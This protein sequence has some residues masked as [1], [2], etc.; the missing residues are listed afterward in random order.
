MRLFYTVLLFL[1]FVHPLLGQKSIHYLWTQE[2]KQWVDGSGKVD[3]KAWKQNPK[4]LKTYLKTLEENPP[5]KYWSK[6]DSLAYFINAYNAVTVDLIL[7][8]YPLKS[9][10]RLGMPWR[11]KLFVLGDKKVSLGHLEH[12]ILRKM[13]DPRIHFAINCASASCPKLENTAFESANVQARLEEVTK[14]FLNDPL[15]NKL[16]SNPVYLS[17]IFFWFSSDFGNKKEKMEFINRY[18][19]I[20]VSSL[21]KV[22]YLEYDWSLN[23]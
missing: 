14:N 13:K 11:R 8:H 22:K 4:R 1:C 18:S 17:K 20:Q 23:E 21:T 16:D 6:N 9:I 2:L 5:Q 19:P 12:Q 7:T 10:R 15:K 3:Y